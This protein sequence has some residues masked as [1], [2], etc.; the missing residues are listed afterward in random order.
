M[1]YIKEH[2][3]T[4]TRHRHLVIKHCYKCGILWQGLRHD[5]SK[6]SPT[7]FLE[8]IRYYRPDRSPNVGARDANGYSRAWMHH[9]GRNRHHFEYWIDYNSKSKKREPVPMPV[10]YVV[11]MF[12]DRIAASKIYFGNEYDDSKTYMY[13]EKGKGKHYMHPRTA[14]MLKKLLI[15]LEKD[16]EEKTFAYIRSVVKPRAKAKH[17][18]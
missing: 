6:Y 8:G 16:G 4:I 3:L 12:C 17:I 5:L 2:F 11:E 15:M 1:L 14:S 7:E 10:R 18:W 13:F 9:Q